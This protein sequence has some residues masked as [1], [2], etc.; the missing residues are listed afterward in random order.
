[1]KMGNVHVVTGGGSGIG[2]AIATMLPK[3]DTVIITGR[4]LAKLEKTAASINESGAHVVATTCDVSQRSD[5]KKLAEYAA[6]LGEVKKV[7]HCAGV[8]GTM[9]DR[10]TIMR[11]NALG[12][13]YVNQ[14][15]YKVM[16][17][18]VI[19]DTAS[20]S[21][22]ILP[23]IMMP[24]KKIFSLAISDEEQFVK[25]MAKKAKLLKDESANVQFAY[26]MSKNFARWYSENCTFKY[27][28]TKGIRV[29]SV[30]PGYVKTPM[31]E[32]EEGEGTENLLSYTGLFRGAEPEEI[33]FLMTS[34]ADER[35]GYFMGADVLVDG[36]CVNNSYSILTAA[37]KY[38][39]KSLKENW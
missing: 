2:K 21:G 4:T 37:K 1:M 31:T 6:S 29:F 19:C 12:T 16:N 34:L 22:Y 35:C 3:E 30:S 33:A 14:E 9:A 13:V 39:K 20:N 38:D 15:F 24:S 18:G 28:V 10:E 11:I 26:M 8:S 7:F 23:K 27:M 25:K 36:G 17:G 32:K 5:V